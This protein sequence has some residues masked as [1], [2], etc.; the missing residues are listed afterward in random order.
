MELKRRTHSAI[1]LGALILAVAA[2]L[3]ADPIDLRDLDKSVFDR[4]KAKATDTVDITLDG[5]ILRMAGGFLA[6]S[7]DEDA[8]KVKKLVEGLRSVTVRSFEFKHKGDYTAAD[9]DAIRGQIKAS[10][11]TRI[12]DVH[13]KEDGDHA[14]IYIL[15]GKDKPQGL[16]ILAAE[17][18]ELTVVHIEG[19]IDPKDLGALRNLGVPDVTHLGGD[20]EGR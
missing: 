6:D 14:E 9:L 5:S 13:S 15:P 7:G 20:K 8:A 17:P 11:W 1:I 10:S 4:L 18:L 19:A 3:A 16:F 12:V 2:P